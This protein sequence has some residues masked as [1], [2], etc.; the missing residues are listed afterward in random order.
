MNRVDLKNWAKDKIEGNKAELWK[1]I[2]LVAI[3]TIASSAFVEMF[4]EKS[5]IGGIIGF[6]IEILLIPVSIGLMH[7]FI[8]FVRT[9]EFNK[10]VIF[11]HYGEFWKLVGTVLIMGILIAIGM[12]F[13]IIPGVYLGLSYSIVPYLLIERK[14][15]SISETLELSRKMMYGKKM[16]F[17]ILGLSFLGWCL[18][19]PFTFGI[20][21]IWLYPYMTTATTKFMVDVIDN[22]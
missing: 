6:I 13:F 12:I 2:L 15:L 20:I 7:F 18:L 4:G 21:L 5:T 10:D 22:Y 3:L 9:G 1:G 14:D 11:D 19:I 16:D 8:I 17:L